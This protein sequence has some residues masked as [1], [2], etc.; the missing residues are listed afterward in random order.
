MTP[1]ATP[2]RTTADRPRRVAARPRRGRMD[3]NIGLIIAVGMALFGIVRFYG[4]SQ[5]NPVTGEKQRV[6]NLTPSQEVALGMQ[7]APRMAEKMGGVLPAG[8]PRTQFVRSVGQKI[9]ATL[10]PDHP[11]KFNFHVLVDPKTVNAFALP[12]GQCFITVGLL[13]QLQNEAQLAGVLGH[14]IGHVIH[15]HSAQHI[16][17]G[18]LGQDLVRAVGVGASGQDN[19]Q[20]AYYAAQMANNMIQLKYGRGDE[21]ESDG[22]GVERMAQAGYDPREMAGVMAILKKAGGG[23]G[24]PEFTSTHP[25]PGNRTQQIEGQIAEAYPNGVPPG[26]TKGATLVN[27]LPE[28]TP[29]APAASPGRKKSTW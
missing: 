21:L 2:R 18:Q 14:E 4:S 12:G 22:Y 27:G 7:S 20:L 24:R 15:R 11:W 6:G 19:G 9:V 8:D 25:D 29:N 13:S 28:G 17:K 1:P 5:P 10:P 26:L 3:L 23:G 16:A